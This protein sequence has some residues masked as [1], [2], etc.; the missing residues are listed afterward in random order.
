MNII[1]KTTGILLL[2]AFLITGCKGDE[3]KYTSRDTGIEQLNAGNYDVAI[4]AFDQALELSDGM[5]GTFELDVLKYR[6]EAEYNIEDYAAAAHTYGVLMQVEEK[7]PEYL[8]MQCLLYIKAGQLDQAVET[9]QTSYAL[10]PG[11]AVTE[12]ALLSLGQEL[13]TADRFE[14]AMALYE[15]AVTD[16]LQSSELYNR[17]GMCEMEAGD[18]DKA[19]EYF[20][21]GAAIGDAEVLPKLLYNQAAAYEQ[22][23][24]FTKALELL[25]SYVSTYGSNAEVEREIAFLKTR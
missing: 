19:L 17:M 11:N 5:V 18:C 15:Q 8:N 21:Q 12:P 24:D 3:Q 22:K 6:A 16:G 9:Y 4:Q 20:D 13:T 1:Y 10:N 23:L 2:S 25:Q 14:E 7:K